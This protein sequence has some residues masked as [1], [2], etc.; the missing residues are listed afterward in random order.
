MNRAAVRV[1]TCDWRHRHWRG[2]FYPV[3]LG[4][5]RW[6]AHYA[7]HFDCVELDTSAHAL[8]DPQTIAAWCAATPE[9]FAFVLK[10]PRLLTHFKKLKGCEQPL[11]EMFARLAL[12]GTRLGAVVF[13]LPLRWRVN[14]PR[15]ESFLT[16]LP[17]ERPPLVF[18][19]R[20][21][22]W[23]CDE[24]HALLRDHQVGLGGDD[25]GALS[26]SIEHDGGY[27][28]LRL[29]RNLDHSLRSETLRGWAGRA[30]GWSRGG[31]QVFVFLDNDARAHAV[32]T[33]RRL[34]GMLEGMP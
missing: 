7:Q 23:R 15:L 18:E 25:L 2:A 17:A 6:L 22:S 19:L 32:R 28:C 31:R 5:D 10:A 24:V 14:L 26:P 27:G 3:T 12:F 9:H 4:R 34:R 29:G 13:E 20:D 16:G 1:G 8:P 21:P 33:A 30:R 11:R